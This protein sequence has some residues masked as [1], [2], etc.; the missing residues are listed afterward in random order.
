MTKKT[1]N[2]PKGEDYVDF[3]SKVKG[4]DT[5]G[6][7]DFFKTVF[8]GGDDVLAELAQLKQKEIDDWR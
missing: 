1:N 7:R 4:V 3:Y 5:F 6:D 8:A 2:I